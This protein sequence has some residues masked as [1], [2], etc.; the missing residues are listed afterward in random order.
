MGD[1]TAPEDDRQCTAMSRR[2]GERCKKYAVTGTN[3]CRTHGANLPGVKAA[4]RERT[5][6]AQAR[7][8][9]IKF[10][11][12]AATVDDPVLELRRVAAGLRARA[13]SLADQIAEGGP[14]A[15]VGDLIGRWD[16]AA[17]DYARV[18]EGMCRLNIDQQQADAVTSVL[19]PEFAAELA[20]IIDALAPFPDARQAVAAA[21]ADLEAHRRPAGAP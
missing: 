13:N 15:K 5:A 19:A 11:G 3:V 7:G 20:T 18:L 6:A 8:L 12:D 21:L 17:L 9:V 14:A 4:A 16:K 2:S 10:D 1:F